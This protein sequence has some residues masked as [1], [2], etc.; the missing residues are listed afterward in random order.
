MAVAAQKALILET[1]HRL[2]DSELAHYSTPYTR[3]PLA[4][5]HY[6]PGGSKIVARRSGCYEGQIVK[7]TNSSIVLHAMVSL[8]SAFLE[9]LISTLRA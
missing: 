3:P 4:I 9:D 5:S 2:P 7:R 8:E 1:P 6:N